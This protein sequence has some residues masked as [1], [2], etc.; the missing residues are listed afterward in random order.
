MRSAAATLIADA[1]AAFRAGSRL[2]GSLF[3]SGCPRPYLR[4]LPSDLIKAPAWRGPF[5]DIDF[6]PAFA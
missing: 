5:F 3:Q 4:S 1:D 6:F 2:L